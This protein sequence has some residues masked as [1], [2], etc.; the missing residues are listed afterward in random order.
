M[1]KMITFA[2]GRNGKTRYTERAPLTSA[3]LGNNLP[4]VATTDG[5]ATVGRRVG[6]VH[7]NDTPVDLFRGGRTSLGARPGC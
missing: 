4:K 5:T 7:N 1:E 6:S 2:D 3:A